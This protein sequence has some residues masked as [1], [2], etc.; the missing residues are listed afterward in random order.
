MPTLYTP[1]APL[2]GD[3]LRLALE[4]A[5]RQFIIY[6]EV[7]GLLPDLSVV[8]VHPLHFR[9]G[10]KRRLD[11]VTVDR[12]HG[13]MLKAQPCLVTKIVCCLHFTRYYEVYGGQSL[14]VLQRQWGTYSQYEYR[15]CHP[16]RIQV[17]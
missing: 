7:L 1:I 11:E 8:L 12:C 3:G 5:S 17:L 9:V 15:T 2:L 10:Q 6:K 4:P 14:Q 16:R 13:S